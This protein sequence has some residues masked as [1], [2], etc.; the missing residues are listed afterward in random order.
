MPYSHPFTPITEPA[1]QVLGPPA[2][3]DC[4]QRERETVVEAEREARIARQE[5]ELRELR[6]LARKEGFAEGRQAGLAQALAEGRETI[7][8][9]QRALEAGLEQVNEEYAS[10]NTCLLETVIS[11]AIQLAE[12]LVG[13]PAAFDRTELYRRLIG[14]IDQRRTSQTEI[15]CRAHPETVAQFAA[16]FGDRVLVDPDTSMAPGGVIVDLRSIEGRQVI[17]RWNASIERQIAAL[18]D[19]GGRS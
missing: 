8:T 12:K 19:L 17:N 2:D 5:R 6:D 16:L 14:T 7:A 18:K 13:M 10:I 11:V 4:T 1:E 9:A 3:G 15:V